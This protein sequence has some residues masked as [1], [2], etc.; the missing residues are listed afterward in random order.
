MPRLALRFY[1]WLY[2]TARLMFKYGGKFVDWFVG[3]DDALLT[4]IPN[5]ANIAHIPFDE[6]VEQVGS[7]VLPAEI[8]KHF[9][10]RGGCGL[11][12]ELLSLPGRYRL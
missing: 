11:Y 7:V 3:R 10:P 6:N 12:Y 9:H 8:I 1:P 5:D 2:R 4:W